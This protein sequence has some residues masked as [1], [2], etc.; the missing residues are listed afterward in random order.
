MIADDAANILGWP[1]NVSTLLGMVLQRC[2]R[3]QQT[4]VRTA[5]LPRQMAGVLLVV[6]TRFTFGIGLWLNLVHMHRRQ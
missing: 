3:T 1:N 2:E 4:L 5:Y 6:V